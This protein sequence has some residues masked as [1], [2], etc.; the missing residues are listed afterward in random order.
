[1]TYDTLLWTKCVFQICFTV[2]FVFAIFPCFGMKERGAYSSILDRCCLPD[3]V[4]TS[5]VFALGCQLLW[6]VR[7]MTHTDLLAEQLVVFYNFLLRKWA[8]VTSD[9]QQNCL[10]WPSWFCLVEAGS[11]IMNCAARKSMAM[12][13]SGRMTVTKLPGTGTYCFGTAGSGRHIHENFLL[14]ACWPLSLNL[15]DCYLFEWI[16]EKSSNH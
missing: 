16:V 9:Q 5:E 3:A 13:V 15:T 12:I 4:L 10:N 7:I 8:V 1:M 14:S 2:Y 11:S 6:A